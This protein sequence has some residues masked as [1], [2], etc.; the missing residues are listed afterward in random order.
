MTSSI[1]RYTEYRFVVPGKAKSF[2]SPNAPRYKKLIRR[3]ARK[4]FRRPLR[5]CELNV[6][7]DYFHL[8]KRRFDMDNVAKCILDALN[9]IAYLDDRMVR[10]QASAS[11]FLGG[12]LFIPGGPVDL[13]KPIR[14][15]NV[16]LFVRVRVHVPPWS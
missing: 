14:R 16:Y 11:H 5:G 15:H 3:E 6:L 1:G 9:G 2:R 4:V 7:V 8:G 13:V 10:W 12:P